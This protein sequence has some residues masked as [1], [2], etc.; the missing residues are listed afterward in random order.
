M[1][2][3]HLHVGCLQAVWVIM[4]NEGHLCI[5]AL[6]NNEVSG[7]V[8]VLDLWRAVGIQ[9]SWV[10]HDVLVK[11]L[12]IE[13]IAASW[14][15]AK[16]IHELIHVVRQ[17]RVT[18]D[19]S[20]VLDDNERWVDPSLA[21]GNL[22]SEGHVD[23]DIRVVKQVCAYIVRNLAKVFIESGLDCNDANVAVHSKVGAWWHFIAESVQKSVPN[24]ATV[25]HLRIL[26]INCV[27]ERPVDAHLDVQ[28]DLSAVKWR[29]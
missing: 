2:L 19:N 10:H 16:L 4:I 17:S 3:E 7:D 28:I 11:D 20:L 21:R 29:G 8:V 13:L 23:D 9:H 27:N 26:L 18:P 22:H 24:L 6:L 1:N 15:L 12:E 25:Q 5:T 14:P